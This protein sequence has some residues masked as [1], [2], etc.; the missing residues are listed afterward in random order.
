MIRFKWST[1]MCV[2]NHHK[3]ANNFENFI[4]I[5]IGLKYAYTIPR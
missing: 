1:N 3:I 5:S 4:R 2:L